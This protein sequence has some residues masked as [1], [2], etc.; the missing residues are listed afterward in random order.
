MISGAP[1]LLHSQELPIAIFGFSVE[2][3]AC[4]SINISEIIHYFQTP[5]APGSDVLIFLG[6]A[7]FTPQEKC[8]FPV[9]LHSESLCFWIAETTQ[10]FPTFI[11]LGVYRCVSA[12]SKPIY[13]TQYRHL[14]VELRL[15]YSIDFFKSHFRTEPLGTYRISIRKS[16]KNLS[17][18]A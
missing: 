10:E 8:T 12:N 9:V 3:S 1:G 5:F 7:W 11:S 6:C 18:G 15:L 14:V 4:G 17:G 2:C 13:A 16:S